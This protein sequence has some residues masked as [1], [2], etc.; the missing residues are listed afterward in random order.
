MFF[1]TAGASNGIVQVGPMPAWEGSSTLGS[2][3]DRT[4]CSTG[5]CPIL[6]KVGQAKSFGKGEV[7]FREDEPNDCVYLIL[8]GVVRGSKVLADGRR[9]IA[10][11]AFPGQ[12]LEYDHQPQ[13]PFTAEAITPVRTIS[14][15]RR[16]FDRALREASCLQSLLTRVLI[17][18]LEE[19]RSQVLAL[20]RLSATER[21]AQFLYSITQASSKDRDGAVQIPMCRADIA[22][23]LGLTIE[24]VS[25]VFSR[26][27]RNGIIKLLDNNRV[28]ILDEDDFV[29]R[30]LADAS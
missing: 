4:N 23:Y 30:F 27:K 1:A 6:R 24:T 10:R 19:A 25:R 16:R 5:Q 28:V 13:C 29:D 22:D 20:G 26:L 18:E 11:F 17:L 21:V 12:L 3:C 14:I 7:I 15:Q 2:E 9:L 8:S